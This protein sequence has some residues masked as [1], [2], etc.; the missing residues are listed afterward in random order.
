MNSPRR[1]TLPSN[2]S[3]PPRFRRPSSTGFTLVEL[4]V[5]I[6]V[7][8]LLMAVG[9]GMLTQSRGE[10]LRSATEQFTSLVEQA[11]TTAIARRTPIMLAIQEPRQSDDGTCRI[12][13]F[14]LTEWNPDA[15]NEGTLVQRWQTLPDGVALFGGEVESLANVKDQRAISLTWKGGSESAEMAGLV[16]SPRGGLLA[17]AGS[18]SVVV[19][20]A[21]GLYRDGNAVRTGDERGK[22]VRVGRVVARPWQ[23]DL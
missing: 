10:A 13:L 20:F 19:T 22:V 16:F 7:V 4:I 2:V 18:E 11:R 8:L 3:R 5:V 14:E 9:V 12:G 15:P 21:A 17:P 1:A 23:M 6:A